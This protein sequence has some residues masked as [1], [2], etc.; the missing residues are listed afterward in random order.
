MK[1]RGITI[2]GENFDTEPHNTN[3]VLFRTIYRNENAFK[4]WT[5]CKILFLEFMFM[6][7]SFYFV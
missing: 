1:Y 3:L 5:G 7:L 4:L 2:L 6:I